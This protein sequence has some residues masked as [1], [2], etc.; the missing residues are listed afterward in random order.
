MTANRAVRTTAIQNAIDS[1]MCTATRR[2]G[3]PEKYCR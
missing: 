1:A 2:A 3:T